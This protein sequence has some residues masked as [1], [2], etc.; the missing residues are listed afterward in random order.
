MAKGLIA[1]LETPI[2]LIG[3]AAAHLSMERRRTFEL[4]P[5]VDFSDQG[6][7]LFGKDFAS[8]AKFTA[9]NFEALKGFISHEGFF[10]E[11]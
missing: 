10:W 8:W 9:D 2:K 5:L 6:P 3:N 11:W 7:L 4:K 1:L